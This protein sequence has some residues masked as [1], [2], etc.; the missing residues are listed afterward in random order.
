MYLSIKYEALTASVPLQ[1]IFDSRSVLN[2]T[3]SNGT[4]RGSYSELLDD[5]TDCTPPTPQECS[6]IHC[7]LLPC[8]KLYMPW[9]NQIVVGHG[10][11]KK[12]I[13]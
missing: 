9:E 1:H 8:R 5:A 10:R 2:I 13:Y 7:F 3:G 12:A 6:C 4:K 11:K